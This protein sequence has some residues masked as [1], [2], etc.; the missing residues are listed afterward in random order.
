M[1]ARMRKRKGRNSWS[2]ECWS[3][4]PLQVRRR[5]RLPHLRHPRCDSANAVALAAQIVDDVVVDDGVVPVV[6]AN[7]SPVEPFDEDAVAEI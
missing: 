6:L 2:T 7:D 3:S 1:N 5:Q 4:H